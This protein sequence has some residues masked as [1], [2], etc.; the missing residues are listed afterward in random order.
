[1][2]FLKAVDAQIEFLNDSRNAVT[3]AVL[4]QG[5]RDLKTRRISGEVAAPPSQKAV[6]VSPGT[7]A[8]YAGTYA[9]APG[10]DVTMSV[11]DGRLMTQ[12]T[13]Q[14]KLELFASSETR[15]F[16]KVVDAQVEFYSDAS[17]R[18]THIVIHQGGRDTKALR[19]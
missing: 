2:F 15:F 17:G 18:V 5:G 10:A 8:K 16:L 4:H 7:L 13:G 9:L 1:M 12:I 11:E 14:P 19:K 6:Q 3:H